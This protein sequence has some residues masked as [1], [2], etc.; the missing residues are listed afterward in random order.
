MNASFFTQRE[1]QIIAQKLQAHTLKAQIWAL[2]REE[3]SSEIDLL[4]QQCKFAAKTVVANVEDDASS[5]HKKSDP[6]GSFTGIEANLPRVADIDISQ[7]PQSSAK[8][9][10]MADADADGGSYPA[11]SQPYA[12][13]TLPSLVESET[14]LQRED[15][16]ENADQIGITTTDSTTIEA[17][18]TRRLQLGVI[19]SFLQQME[20]DECK[21]LTPKHD[22]SGARWPHGR[23][24]SKEIVRVEGKLSKVGVYTR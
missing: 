16:G 10:E 11:V 7:A 19:G 2:T 13:M 6:S 20:V 4:I 18:P 12:G 9:E 21:F 8:D 24:T 17:G 3:F 1:E 14:T 5:M 22:Y 23:P 15:V